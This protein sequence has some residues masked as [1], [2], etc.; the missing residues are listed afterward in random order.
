MFP[1]CLWGTTMANPRKT[2]FH[3]DF[4]DCLLVQVL[5]LVSGMNEKE[6]D[7]SGISA[8]WQSSTDFNISIPQ[9]QSGR[10]I[11]GREGQEPQ[12]IPHFIST[13]SLPGITAGS[14]HI[15]RLRSWMAAGE[16]SVAVAGEAARRAP[17][18]K[19]QALLVLLRCHSMQGLSKQTFTS[20]D[21]S[22]INHADF[23]LAKRRKKCSS[24]KTSKNHIWRQKVASCSS[25]LGWRP[26]PC[27]PSALF[28]TLLCGFLSNSL[29]PHSNKR[30]II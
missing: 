11:D 17:P 12:K 8:H 4:K 16:G 25:H 5:T 13:R 14:W 23:F 15:H 19:K 1:V 2:Q 26:A 7:V 6:T 24:I 21:E 18:H 30:S 27:A 22:R 28:H 9:V 3:L 29:H 20:N 10:G